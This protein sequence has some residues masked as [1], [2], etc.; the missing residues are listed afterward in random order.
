MSSVPLSQLTSL[1]TYASCSTSRLKSLYSDFTYQKQSNPTSYS[2]NVEW[3]R[4]T[5][6]G[7]LLRGWLSESHN[8]AAVPDRLVLHANGVSFSDNFRVE[9]VGKPLSIPTVISELCSSK[10]LIPFA[11]FMNASR[12]IYDPG[13]LP[14]RIASVVVGKP[15]W[16]ALGQLGI[17]DTQAGA[18][19]DS[20][21]AERWKKVKGNYV[22]VSLLERAAERILERQ[23]RKST[24]NIADVLYNVDGFRE[25]FAACAFEGAPLSDSDIRVVLKF[26]ERDKR[27]VVVKG[28]VI[29]FLEQGVSE[30]PEVTAV[31]N[32]ILALKTAVEKLQKQVD[33][34]QHRI[35]ERTRQIS[36]SLRQK[37][38]EIAL[39][40]LRSR[41]QLEEVRQKRLES[42]NLLESTLLRVET[43]AG[44]IE[45]MKSYQ[46]STVTLREILSHQLLQRDKIDETMDAMASANADAREVDDAIQMGAEMA[47]AEAGV[48]E[49]ELEAELRAL[50]QDVEK[51]KEEAAVQAQRDRLAA[52]GLT[53]PMHTPSSQKAAEEKP[54]Q[55]EPVE[56]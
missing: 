35:D 5:L 29:K 17:V 43:S 40:Q 47:H 13:W 10:A 55:R 8:A 16:W 1:P 42:L 20:S 25:E 49:S 24:G 33:G 30:T 3:W 36:E 37:R 46:S 31:D 50:V 22:V 23:R 18:F 27:T 28:E 54:Q 14:Y 41:K 53:A 21:T 26:L 48:D 44:D 2:S 34:L 39:A 38:K 45:I 19:G 11:D 32:G 51:E 52:G 12:S 15:L 7:A 9:G 56:A 6:E 4:R